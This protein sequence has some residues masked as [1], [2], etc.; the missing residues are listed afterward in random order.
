MLTTIQTAEKAFKEFFLTP[1]AKQLDEK[2][3]PFIAMLK[4]STKEVSGKSIKMPL[5]FGRSGGIGNRA[6]DGDLPTPNPRKWEQATWETKNIYGRISLSGKSIQASRDDKGAFVR[7]LRTQMDD[8]LKDANNDLR[9]QSFG[10][11]TGILSLIEATG[12]T[13]GV[14]IPVDDIKYFSVG[15]FVDVIKDSD[16]STIATLR[17][18]LVVDKINKTITISGANITAVDN[19]FL[20]ISGNYNNELTGLG[21]VMTLDSTLY[22][23][24]RSTNKWMNPNLEAVGGEITEIVMQKAIDDADENLGS[25]IDFIM[26]NNGVAR[27]FQLNQLS[28][29]KNIKTMT[30]AGG[31]KSMAYNDIPIA[32]DKYHTDNA[33]TFIHKA[34]FSLMRMGDWDWMQRDGSI[35]SR[36]TNK[37]AYEATIYMYGDIGCKRVG[38]QSMLTGITEH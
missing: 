16:K 10:N 37:D 34:D 32:R 11:G 7:L 29:K 12:V 36:I 25:E 1:A 5:V 8:L 28:Y 24:D 21:A 3:G 23:I 13:A 6:E 26:C 31:Y 9:R 15:K 30:I 17:E 4:K 2:S 18:V 19:D 27:G 35:F 22:G 14:V 38:G 33:M 20:V